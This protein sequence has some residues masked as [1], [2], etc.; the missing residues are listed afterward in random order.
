MNLQKYLSQSPKL[1]CS[2]GHTISITCHIVSVT[3]MV[4]TGVGLYHGKLHLPYNQNCGLFTQFV[5][6]HPCLLLIY[7][8]FMPTIPTSL[9]SKQPHEGKHAWCTPHRWFGMLG[10]VGREG[11]LTMG[12]ALTL[13]S[14]LTHILHYLLWTWVEGGG[15]HS[16]GCLVGAGTR[17]QHGYLFG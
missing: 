17:D 5:L 3:G 10:G 9:G 6:V 12:C 16:P 13:A 14:S 7:P 1:G 15:R 8:L 11:E 4:Y 2:M